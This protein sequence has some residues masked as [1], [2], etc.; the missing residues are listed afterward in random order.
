MK[1]LIIVVVA[2]G[3][4]G[5]LAIA[6]WLGPVL[7]RRAAAVREYKAQGFQMVE[8]CN[9]GAAVQADG[10]VFMI[11]QYLEEFSDSTNM[12]AQLQSALV[13]AQEK[14]RVLSEDC[15]RRGHCETYPWTTNWIVIKQALTAV[16]KSN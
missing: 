7:Y 11:K 13:V 15:R 4:V 6:A 3:V 14:A 2:V 16:E 10:Q 12:V 1:K 8:G 5:A 9:G